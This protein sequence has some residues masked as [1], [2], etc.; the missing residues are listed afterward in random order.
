[1]PTNTDHAR[2]ATGTASVNPS[3]RR[4]VR[5]DLITLEQAATLIGVTQATLQRWTGHGWVQDIKIGENDEVRYDPELIK[6][7]VANLPGFLARHEPLMELDEAARLLCASKISLRR[8][9]R[10]GVLE[11]ERVGDRFD[12][13]FRLYQLESYLRNFNDKAY[14]LTEPLMTIEDARREL[15]VSKISIRRWAKAGQLSCVLI[16]GRGDRR[17]FPQQLRQYVQA[18]VREATVEEVLGEPDPAEADLELVTA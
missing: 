9:T 3:R 12:R 5:F 11:C 2:A 15:G 1:M 13:R 16:N 18:R 7:L 6:S 8:W 14:P 17:F 4:K 10:I